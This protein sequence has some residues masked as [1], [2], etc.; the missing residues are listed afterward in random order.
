MQWDPVEALS[1]QIV[2]TMLLLMLVTVVAASVVAY[3]LAR[4]I[5][6]PIATL[7][8]SFGE[9]KKGDLGYRITQDRKDEFGEL[10]RSFDDMADALQK[11]G[12][13]VSAS[14]GE[15]K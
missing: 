14:D 6:N 3:V 1:R 2:V 5:S 8:K 11:R 9:I 10:F 12:E 15:N 4:G 7:R 13:S